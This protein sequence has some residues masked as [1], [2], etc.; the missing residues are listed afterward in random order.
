MIAI[1][2]RLRSNLRIRRDRRKGREAIERQFR[3]FLSGG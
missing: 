2:A 1:S 3:E